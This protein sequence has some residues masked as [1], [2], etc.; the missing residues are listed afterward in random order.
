MILARRVPIAVT[1]APVT[2]NQDM[3]ALIPA[4]QVDADFLGMVLLAARD[5]LAVLIDE[6][7]HGTKRLP[8][9]RWHEL[10]IPVPP[11]AEQVEVART[12]SQVTAGIDKATTDAT[13]ESTL[14]REASVRLISDVVA[15]KLDVRAAAASLPDLG[16]EDGDAGCDDLETKNGESSG[17]DLEDETTGDEE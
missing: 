12:I 8:T 17:E 13:T 4:A 1:E 5:A 3:K 2:L 6:A 7:G 9:E 10:P 15:G 16:G 11:L 14:V